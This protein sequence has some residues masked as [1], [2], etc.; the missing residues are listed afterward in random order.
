VGYASVSFAILRIYFSFIY[1]A[2]C[3]FYPS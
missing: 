3:Q 1:W 2:D